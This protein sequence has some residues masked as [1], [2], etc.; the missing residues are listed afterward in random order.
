[1]TS[2]PDL[3]TYQAWCAEQQVTIDSLRQDKDELKH[4][5][6]ELEGHVATLNSMVERL[7]I[8]ISQG[9]EL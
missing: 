3:L 1:M 8:A 4:R 9:R 7:Q 6:A 2:N 5:I